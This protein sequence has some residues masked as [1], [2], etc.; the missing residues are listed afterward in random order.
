MWA[1]LPK[2]SPPESLSYAGDTGD[3]KGRRERHG[4]SRE[5]CWKNVRERGLEARIAVPFCCLPDLWPCA[6]P[7]SSELQIPYLKMGII[8]NIFHQGFSVRII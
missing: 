8:F 1:D 5:L 4:G 7:Y 6:G 2:T 3:M